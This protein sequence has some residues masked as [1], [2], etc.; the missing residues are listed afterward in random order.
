[1]LT[2]LALGLVTLA[3]AQPA[4]REPAPVAAKTETA[5]DSALEQAKALFHKGNLLRKTGDCQRALE[6]Y[7]Q[8]RA[9]VPSVPNTLNAAFCLNQLGRF[10]EALETYET[11]LLEF[12][13]ELTG[14][15]PLNVG[16][17]QG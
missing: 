15:G 13:S 6:L 9:L 16:V 7:L 3:R 14:T 12:E 11:A 10:D 17:L 1:V 2:L 8:S 4:E 5:S